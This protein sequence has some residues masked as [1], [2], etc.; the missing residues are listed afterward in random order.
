MEICQ[1]YDVDRVSNAS[2][3]YANSLGTMLGCLATAVLSHHW[4]VPL[5]EEILA[6]PIPTL[7]IGTW[8]AYRLYP[9]VPTIDLHKYWEA[10]KPVI[11]EP[12]LIPYDIYR[13]TAIWL[14]LFM[15]IEVIFGKVHSIFLVPIFTITVLCARV[16]VIGTILSVAE[17][18]GGALALCIWPILL[19]LHQRRRALMV[20]LLLVAYVV[21]E[22]L[23]PFEFLAHARSF[24]WIPF[25]SFMFGS[26][27]VNVLSFLEKI[28]LYGSLLFLLRLTGSR[29]RT[30][31][32]FVVGLL[33]VTSWIET[34]LPDRSAEITDAVLALLV[35]AG[36]ALLGPDGRLHALEV[37]PMKKR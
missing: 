19:T 23:E 33:F 7:L 5:L 34:Y 22:R 32:I 11:L 29:L 27:E 31:T 8:A 20:F 13:H 36:L 28:F 16:L 25:R 14:T 12:H 6:Q 15:L 1:Y 35:A 24:G 17:I 37:T 9:Y 30:A 3:I 21:V 26:M 4:R 2:D 18:A 10:L